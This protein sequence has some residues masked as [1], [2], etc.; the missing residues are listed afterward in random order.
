MP[1]RVT[2]CQEYFDTLGD[3]FVVA[4]APKAGKTFTYQYD[5]EGDGGGTW[6]VVVTSDGPA[7]SNDNPGGKIDVVYTMDASEY[8]QLANGD[9]DGRKA[10]MTRKL[11]VKGSIPKAQKMNKFL[12]PGCD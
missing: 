9:I 3:R 5:L 7:V 12:P 8:V 2:T 1:A 4:K 6:F 11:K 10:F